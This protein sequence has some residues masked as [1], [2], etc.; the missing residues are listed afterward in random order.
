MNWETNMEA[1]PKDRFVLVRIRRTIGN[2]VYCF[3]ARKVSGVWL[4]PC[5]TRVETCKFVVDG[6]MELPE[7]E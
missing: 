1:A 2:W 6:W 3:V 7:V 5:K 4:F